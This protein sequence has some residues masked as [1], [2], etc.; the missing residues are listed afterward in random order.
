MN[1]L[2]RLSESLLSGS[3]LLLVLSQ[4]SLEH[5]TPFARVSV[6]PVTLRRQLLFQFTYHYPQRV[7]HENLDGHAATL[8]VRELFPG[9]FLQAALFACDA[10]TTFH[11]KANGQLRVKSGPPT[12]RSVPTEHN[13]SKEYLI[14]PDVPCPFLAE[15]GVM[16]AEG[17]VRAARYHKFRQ[18]NRFLELVE[19]V[20]PALTPLAQ[21]RPLRVVDFGCGKS[22]LTFAL[23]YLLTRLHGL[24]VRSIGLDLKAS[25][26]RD[27]EALARRLGC[28]GLEF[29]VGDIAGHTET[30][31]VDLAVSLH[32][33]DTATDAALAQAVRWQC[34]VI[35]AVPCCQH[36]LA[37]QL[38]SE[39]LAPLLEY[40]ILRERFAALAT[41]ALRARLLEHHGYTTQIVEFID[42]EHTA[43]NLLLRA[44]RRPHDAGKG[45]VTDA[46]YI[47]FKELLGI[48]QFALEALLRDGG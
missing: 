17:Q 19:D 26:V 39:E 42:L 13:R 10:D 48:K 1:A 12:K 28:H 38:K 33:C 23:H 46:E 34:H 11:V 40:G 21:E 45:T 36:E 7:T 32:A 6:R 9:S 4:P 41:D 22:Y 47:R 8:R 16:T 30:E 18:I 20:M 15:L 14:P 37:P 5:P 35:L 31:P 27:C 2:D 44:V 24:R 25:V 43:K 29:R 3:C